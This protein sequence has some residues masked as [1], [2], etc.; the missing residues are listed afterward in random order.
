MRDAL[1]MTCQQLRVAANVSQADIAERIGRDQAFISRFEQLPDSG[2]PRWPQQLTAILEAYSEALLI[3]VEGLWAQAMVTWGRNEGF[4]AAVNFFGTKKETAEEV[5]TSVDERLERLTA[6]AM[7]TVEV[8]SNIQSKLD[9]VLADT[10]ERQQ[11][12]A[13]LVATTLVRPEGPEA[14]PPSPGGS[15]SSGETR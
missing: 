12:L 7:A 14:S 13:E 9:E 8:V 5:V 10:H 3:P 6:V 1:I 15:S 11:R 2:N 4:D